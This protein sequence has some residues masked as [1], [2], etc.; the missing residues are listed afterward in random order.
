[1]GGQI[2]DAEAAYN[3]LVVQPWVDA[4][5]VGV[6]GFSLG[7]GI[8][9]MTAGTHPIFGSNLWSHGL[10]WVISMSISGCLLTKRA[11]S[12]PRMALW[13]WILGWRTIA[14][15]DFFA[16]M[17]D[18]DIAGVIAQY[19]GVYLAVAGDQDFSAAYAPGL[20]DAAPGAP[21]EAWIIPDGDHIYQVLSDDQ[22]MADAV[23]QRTA[24]WFAATL[25][26]E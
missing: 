4:A 10:R 13:A 26:A 21:T 2:E 11:E 24:D 15:N 3:W 12:P 9:I 6:L 18:Y 20:A 19:P 1:M 8:A 17:K 14:K 23:I 7:G 16:T 5:R 22:T 25:G